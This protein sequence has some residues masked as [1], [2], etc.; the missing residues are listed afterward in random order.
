MSQDLRLDRRGLLAV[1]GVAAAVPA[2]MALGG[3]TAQAAA[4]MLGAARP[5]FYRFVHGEFE[6]TT[7][8]DGAVALDGPHPIF[9]QDQEASAVQEL[10]AANHLPADKMEIAFSPVVV[11]TGSELVLFDGGNGAGAKPA[12]GHL[13]DNLAAAGYSADQID[14]VVITHMHP[15]HIGGLMAEGAP[16]FS[17]ARYVTAAAEYDFWS[18]EDKL[19][20]PTERVAKL[21][22]SNVVPLADKMSFIKSGDDVVSG[23]TSIDASGH[24]PGHMAYN[25]ESSGK[26]LLLWADAA[27]HF[28]VSIQRPDWHVRFDM[29]KEKAASTRKALFDMAAAD[30]VA[31]TGYHM[32]GNALGY[33]NKSDAGYRWVPATYQLSL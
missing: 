32:P 17:N 12:R 18:P 3:R 26:R 20:G 29:D 13:L 33:I 16:V 28:V 31:V 21:V 5:G 11:N 14:V 30:G 10:A 27:N 1:A 2:T 7:V 4:P 25:I 22:Q 24:T 15:D 19:T 8:S 9:G 6:V 23:I